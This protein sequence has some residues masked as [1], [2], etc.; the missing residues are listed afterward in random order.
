VYPNK[1]TIFALVI[2][3]TINDMKFNKFVGER[4]LEISPD[5]MAAFSN[6]ISNIIEKYNLPLKVTA[7]KLGSC[8]IYYGATTNNEVEVMVEWTDWENLTEFRNKDKDYIRVTAPMV[9]RL[10]KTSGYLDDTDWAT[11]K[12]K[13]DVVCNYK[14][15][16]AYQYN[17]HPN[18]N[19]WIKPYR[20][21]TWSILR[22]PKDAPCFFYGTEFADMEILEY[23]NGLINLTQK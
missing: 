4:M 6:H 10:T 3:K 21:R 2:N 5:E 22:K 8:N 15:A 16:P 12:S 7:S 14:D 18:T 17:C 19:M 20:K 13:D 23:I 9:F 11:L 1:F